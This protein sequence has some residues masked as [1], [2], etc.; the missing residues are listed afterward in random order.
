MAYLHTLRLGDDVFIATE[1]KAFLADPRFRPQLDQD[2]A[3]CRVRH[4]DARDAMGSLR[5]WGYVDHLRAAI[6]VLAA[7]SYA[8]W[9]VLLPLTG[10]LDSRLLP[11]ARPAGVS[12]S[13]PSP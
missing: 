7:D 2:A 13:M 4:W 5:G 8:G 12:T 11:A 1:V 9:S 6:E 3:S 10:G